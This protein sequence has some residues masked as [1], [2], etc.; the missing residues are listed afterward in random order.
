MR[1][2]VS[3]SGPV[4]LG[5]SNY[6]ARSFEAETIQLLRRRE[7]VLL[8]GPRQH[9]KTSALI[10]I[11]AQLKADG[12]RSAIVDLQA[13]PAELSF[14]DMLG[15]FAASVAK[16]L[17]VDPPRLDGRSDSLEDW[18]AAVC[19]PGPPIVVLIDEAASIRDEATRNAFF[20]QIRAF[21]SQAASD[22]DCVAGLLTFAFSGTFRPETLV[23]DKNSPFNVC[24]RVES[25]DLDEA[26]VMTLASAVLGEDTPPQ[27]AQMIFARIGG[28]PELAQRLLALASSAGPENAIDR[29]EGQLSEWETHSN[30]HLDAVFRIVF[31]EPGLKAIA[32][33]LVASGEL[34]IDPA[35]PD[36]R[37]AV[38]T[39]LCRKSGNR[40]RF[41][42]ALVE[43]VARESPQLHPEDA[44]VRNAHFF[45]LGP[46]GFSFV[47]DPI[48]S[49]IA[50]SSYDGAIKCMRSGAYRLAL[51]G[52][53]VC[54]E[55]VLIDFMLRQPA[56]T[57][58][59]AISAAPAGTGPGFNQFESQIDPESWRLVNLLKVGRLLR[60][61]QNVELPETLRE[62]RNLVHPK[63]IKGSYKTEEQTY[64]EAVTAIGLAGIVFRDFA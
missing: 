8:L 35:N 1:S 64:P 7:W 46:N 43:A 18:L 21:K 51:A 16:G 54:I 55:A 13:M 45:P 17:K 29:I 39:G 20:G 47:A 5:L 9:G 63:L 52:L 25:E 62:F 57:V 42:S 2:D 31:R 4:P 27:I 28:Q 61:G 58:A 11:N 34:Q 44:A 30:D 24:Q 19:A 50:T 41:R 23:D 59:A 49:E 38:V 60:A 12:F 40:L 14:P 48:Y 53:G 22:P 15:W 56:G 26:G 32:T 36:F 37:Y 33:A 6:V 10:R 3:S